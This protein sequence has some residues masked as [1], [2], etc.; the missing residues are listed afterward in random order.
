M[1]R[2]LKKEIFAELVVISNR[3][4]ALALAQVPL[5]IPADVPEWLSPLVAIVPAQLF[6]HHLTASMGFD[7]DAPRI[8]H[9]V[10]R[11]K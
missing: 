9:K 6:A 8:I 1:L 5:T 7:T 2:R 3:R 4:K 10:T 11:T